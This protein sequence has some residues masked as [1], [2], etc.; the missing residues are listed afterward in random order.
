MMALCWRRVLPRKRRAAGDGGDGI[1]PDA[2]AL[3]PA[4]E[5]LMGHSRTDAVDYDYEIMVNT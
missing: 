2:W 4:G 5:F 1:D 3:V